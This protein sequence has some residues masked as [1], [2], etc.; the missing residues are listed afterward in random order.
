VV[1]QAREN[2]A[3]KSSHQNVRVR[4]RST[5]RAIVM[6]AEIRKK[7]KAETAAVED[8]YEENKI[9]RASAYT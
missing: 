3:Q 1:K 8:K 6:G 9:M 5:R 2:A 7:D 4:R